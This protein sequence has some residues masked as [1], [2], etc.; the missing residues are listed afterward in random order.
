MRPLRP[1][2]AQPNLPENQHFTQGLADGFNADE[3]VWE[4][5][6]SLRRLRRLLRPDDDPEKLKK[7]DLADFARA[8]P[9]KDCVS[10]WEVDA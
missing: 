8:Q 7:Q 9:P 10:R 6:A 2:N 1:A 3:R 4:K 5:L